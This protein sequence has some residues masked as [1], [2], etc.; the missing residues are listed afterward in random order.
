MTR[1]LYRLAMLAALTSGPA[2]GDVITLTLSN[3]TVSTTPGSTITFLASAVNTGSQLLNLNGDGSSVPAPL[4][5]DD[6]AFFNDWPLSLDVSESY[7]VPTP[8]A[9]FSVTVPLGTTPA[10]YDGFFEILGGP[11]P[12]DADVLGTADFAITVA[13]T[14]SVPEPST[15]VLAGLAL[16][17]GVFATSRQSLRQR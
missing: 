7:G 3:G 15:I 11:G 17:L 4:T 9:L 6:S 8:Q 12:T 16:C 1:T 14:S 10:V 5:L 2:V 13:S